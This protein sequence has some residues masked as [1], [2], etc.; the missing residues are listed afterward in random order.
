VSNNGY[1]YTLF[2]GGAPRSQP[3]GCF[4][5][6]RCDTYCWKN[7]SLLEPP[8]RFMDDH[9]AATSLSMTILLSPASSTLC[10]PGLTTTPLSADP[11]SNTHSSGCPNSQ[12]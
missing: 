7:G 9:T 2:H 4:W 11:H 5:L 12:T 8:L 10:S 3:D 1:M 6:V